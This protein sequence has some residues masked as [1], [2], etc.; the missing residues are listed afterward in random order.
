VGELITCSPELA[1]AIGTSCTTKIN[2]RLSQKKLKESK[3]K[4]RRK[5]RKRRKRA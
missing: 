2:L 1:E 3:K 4:K 5:R